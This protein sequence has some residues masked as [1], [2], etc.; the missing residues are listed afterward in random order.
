MVHTH[1]LCLAASN[2]AREVGVAV[3]AGDAVPVQLLHGLAGVGVVAL[4]EQLVAA[5][6][7]AAAGCT[8]LGVSASDVWVAVGQGW[9]AR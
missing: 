7:A 5:V 3:E 4:A 6:G 1:I 9:C 8:Q 2:A